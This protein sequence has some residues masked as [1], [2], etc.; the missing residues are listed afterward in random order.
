VRAAQ[1][2]RARYARVK[3]SSAWKET[4][5]LY[6]S[7]IRDRLIADPEFAIVFRAEAAARTREWNARLRAA[8]PARHA[9]MKVEKRA[10]RA[11]W[12]KRLESDPV[13][14]SK[15]K[16]AC[17]AWYAT[18]SDAQR[19]R[20]FNVRRRQRPGRP[21]VQWPPSI[22]QLLGVVQDNEVA[23]RLGVH[24][25]TVAL[26]RQELGIPAIGRRNRLNAGARA[27]IG[28]TVT[29]RAALKRIARMEGSTPEK[30]LESLMSR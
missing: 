9:A 7:K 18:L 12:R 6:L 17:R 8:D 26:K 2:E 19:D 11:A 25:I 15:H 21:P 22:I 5:S 29:L 24:A 3:D 1:R 13:A 20:I 23:E 16:A 27:R 28:L 30:V 14:W 4:R 10:E